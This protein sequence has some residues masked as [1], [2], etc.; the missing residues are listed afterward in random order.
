MAVEIAH[1]RCVP[2]RIGGSTSDLSRLLS[3]SCFSIDRNAVSG[4]FGGFELGN[5]VLSLFGIETFSVAA[6]S[7]IAS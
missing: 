3:G 7:T 5:I 6:R 4:H 2:T 1:A